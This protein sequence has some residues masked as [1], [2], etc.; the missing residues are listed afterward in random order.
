MTSTLPSPYEGE[1]CGR[2]CRAR[3]SRRTAAGPARSTPARRMAVIDYGGLPP[4]EI[5]AGVSRIQQS[6]MAGRLH[7]TV[8]QLSPVSTWNVP[9]V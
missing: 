8:T 7:C 5:A 1:E 6:S 9:T 4:F 2:T 3:F